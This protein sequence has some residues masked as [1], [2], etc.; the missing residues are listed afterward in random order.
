MKRYVWIPVIVLS[1]A[2]FVVLV[3]LVV[4]NQKENDH[5]VVVEEREN[6]TLEENDDLLPANDE[7]TDTIIP[8]SNEV[9]AKRNILED[10]VRT[11]AV[12]RYK[13]DNVINSY[14][15]GRWQ[16]T[17]DTGWYCVFYDEV[18]DE[19]MC[20]GKEWNESENVLEEDLPFHKNGWFRWR[21]KDGVLHK[22]A[23]MNM[24][25]AIIH[26]SYSV[27]KMKDN[28]LV[29]QEER[30]ASNRYSFVKVGE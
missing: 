17:D 26:K 27:I 23:V 3:V 20:W 8:E 7:E 19:G 16:N 4:R 14:V 21:I 29:M 22:F 12:R 30:Y 1:V 25:N 10:S 24:S 5:A 9:M 28:M 18:D 2:V 11:N 15:V 6:E 13:D